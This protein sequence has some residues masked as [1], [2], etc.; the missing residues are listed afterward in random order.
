MPMPVLDTDSME[1]DAKRDD[2]WLTAELMLGDKRG[3]Y[4]AGNVRYGLPGSS[5]T[6]LPLFVPAPDLLERFE[7]CDKRD[8]CLSMVMC[9]GK[10]GVCLGMPPSLE[11]F[12]VSLSRDN[13]FTVVSPPGFGLVGRGLILAADSPSLELLG[14]DL[15][16]IAGIILAPVSLSLESFGTEVS[17][18]NF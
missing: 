6:L 13:P 9:M 12:G 16:V 11:A 8:P 7:T 4:I 1:L 2:S 5:S 10:S 14:A 18:V 3:T 15:P 17:G